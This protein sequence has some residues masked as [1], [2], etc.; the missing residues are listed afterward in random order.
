VEDWLCCKY[1]KDTRR[2]NEKGIESREMEERHHL[3]FTPAL[4]LNMGVI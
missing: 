4:F 1:I 2:N 3:K